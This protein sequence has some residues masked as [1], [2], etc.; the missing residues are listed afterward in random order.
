MRRHQEWLQR[1]AAFALGLST[2]A[3]LLAVAWPHIHVEVDQPA[4]SDAD[5]VCRSCQL[6]VGLSATP[7]AIPRLPIVS[8]P[9]EQDTPQR[10]D[11]LHTFLVVRITAPRA[12]PTFA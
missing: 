11:G 1:G 12:P 9:V 7:P 5:D 6:T 3:L 10:H 4:L 8:V 2:M